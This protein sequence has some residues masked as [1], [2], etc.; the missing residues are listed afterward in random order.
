MELS[1]I[2][3]RTSRL[4]SSRFPTIGVFDDIA[5]NE[6]DLRAAFQL[7]QLTNGRLQPLQRLRALPEGEILTGATATIAMAAF[8]HCSDHGSRFNDGS[9]GAWYAATEIETAIAETVYHNERRLRASSGGFPNRIQMR[10]LIVQFDAGFLDLR[11]LRAAHPE[12]YHP[13]DYSASQAFGL[14]RRWPFV[15][16]PVDGIVY[17]SVRRNGGTNICIFRPK[18]IHL[19]VIQGDHFDYVWDAK[20][21]LADVIRLTSVPIDNQTRP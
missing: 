17:D 6:E 20:G 10:E 15:S 19:P 16:D 14:Q 2:I 4:I 9:L 11:G 5:S 7:E 13:T 3:S 1:W 12:L 21:R 8:I 18:A